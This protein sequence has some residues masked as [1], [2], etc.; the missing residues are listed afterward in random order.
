MHR[1]LQTNHS[2]MRVLCL[3]VNKRAWIA[4]WEVWGVTL[5]ET[6]LASRDRGDDM[7]AVL[8]LGALPQ[9]ATHGC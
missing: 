5:A 1:I 8:A 6:V 4:L 7:R 9:P 3:L 2:Q